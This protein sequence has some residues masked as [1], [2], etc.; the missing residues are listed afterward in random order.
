M[1]AYA[2]LLAK[3]RRLIA[4]AEAH[5]RQHPA[6]ALTL[7]PH[8]LAALATIEAIARDPGWREQTGGERLDLYGEAAR[9]HARE[10]AARTAAAL[11]LGHVSPCPHL[12]GVAVPPGL[13]YVL[14][15]YRLIACAACM[16]AAVATAPG[17]D[18]RTCDW[19]RRPAAVFHPVLAPLGPCLVSGAA[20]PACFA[21]LVPGGDVPPKGR[22]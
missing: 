16:Q 15:S 2:R 22:G 10:F 9:R 6:L 18:D 19:C 5:H 7:L 4:E 12:D 11:E 21:A 14:L 8:T 1:S 13:I 17:P 3:Y 20:C